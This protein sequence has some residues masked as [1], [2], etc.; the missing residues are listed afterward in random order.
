[1]KTVFPLDIASRAS[2]LSE[3]AQIVEQL[4]E[5][6][7]AIAYDARLNALEV[8]KVNTLAGKLAGQSLKISLHE[9]VPARYTRDQLT[10]ILTAHKLLELNLHH[11]ADEEKSL[12]TE[13]HGS[14]LPT[15]QSS[16]QAFGLSPDENLAAGWREPEI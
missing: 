2:N 15:Y 12:L 6:G 16:L 3:R 7:V 14:W 8:W 9:R 13:I 5:R 1:L 4:S 11:L 10:S